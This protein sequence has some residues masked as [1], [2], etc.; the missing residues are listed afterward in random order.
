MGQRTFSLPGSKCSSR[1]R[2]PLVIFP[3]DF[4]RFVDDHDLASGSH[5][6]DHFFDRA[7]LVSEEVDAAHVKHAVEGFHAERQPLRFSVE[8]VRTPIPFL[9]VLLAFAQHAPRDIDSI[10]LDVFGEIAQVRPGAD[11]HFEH[12][13]T[14]GDFEFADDFGTEIGCARDPF[15]KPLSQVVAGREAVIH[16]LVLQV[17]PGDR[18]DEQ[19]DAVANGVDAPGCGIAQSLTVQLER[20]A[21]V[22]VAKHRQNIVFPF[23]DLHVFDIADIDSAQN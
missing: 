17:G 14:I 5:H 9:Q 19:G 2:I 18:T 3:D 10:K 20:V 15:V 4:F 23:V 22:G 1:D 16:G 7:R 11:G 12:A 21:R 8:E 13:R 6:P